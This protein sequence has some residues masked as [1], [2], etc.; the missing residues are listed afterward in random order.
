V[1]T[2]RVYVCDHCGAECTNEHEFSLFGNWRRPGAEYIPDNIHGCTRAHA[3]LAVAK[4]I[5]I[6]V[7]GKAAELIG[8]ISKEREEAREEASRMRGELERAEQERDRLRQEVADL[9]GRNAA[10]DACVT[11]MSLEEGD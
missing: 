5:G 1:T 8:L 9:R 3:C 10:L 11:S 7:D 4:A 2:K 6:G